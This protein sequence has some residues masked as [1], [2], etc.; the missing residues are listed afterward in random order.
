[1]KRWGYVKG[2]VNYKQIAEQV[3]LATDAKA[4]MAEMQLGGPY[5]TPPSETYAKY[6]I[7][8]KEFDPAKP[9]EYVSS[10]AIKRT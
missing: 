8:G 1:M 2:D 4:V 3:Y 5:G 6:T 9:D 7:M 10:F